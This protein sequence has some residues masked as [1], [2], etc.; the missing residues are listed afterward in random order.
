MT[1]EIFYLSSRWLNLIP[2][3]ILNEYKECKRIS[4]IV[5]N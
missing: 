4:S 1:V 5:W 2:N 3:D